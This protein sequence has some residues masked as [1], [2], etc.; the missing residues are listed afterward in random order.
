MSKFLA[1]LELGFTSLLHKNLAVNIL[2]SFARGL[3]FSGAIEKL[4]GNL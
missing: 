2:A 1:L 3:H 4:L